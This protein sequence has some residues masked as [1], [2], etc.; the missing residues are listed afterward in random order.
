MK[1][2]HKHIGRV[3]I[4][5]LLAVNILVIVMLLLSAFCGHINPHTFGSEVSLGLL[6]PFL[7][8]ATF[9]FMI[10]WLIAGSKK[11]LWS[12]G[13]LLLCV[14]K[15]HTYCPVSMP[16]PVP[17]G[18]IKVVSY[19]TYGLGYGMKDS[20]AQAQMM[21]YLRHSDA[22]LLC[23]QESNYNL[24]HKQAVEE[25]VAH[26]QYTDSVFSSKS[27]NALTIYSKYPILDR[28]IIHSSSPG[29]MCVVYRVKIE[30]DTVYVVNCH[31]ISNSI[32]PEDKATYQKLVTI[33]DR[34]ITSED[35]LRLGRKVNDAGL[36]R[37]DQADSLAR[38][39]E[40]LGDKPVIVCGDFNE[41]P[42]GYVHTR[43]CRLLN[44]AYTASGNGPGIT[45]HLNKMYFRLDNILC[46][47]HWRSFG[48]RV[49]N[50]QK[51]SDHYPIE[52]WLKR[53][54]E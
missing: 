46:S 52:A 34:D 43:L 7:A 20:A 19:N 22:D 15:L 35:F 36:R 42:L 1:K 4:K 48:A 37:A 18:S 26:W 40:Q 32:N 17:K 41:S 45:Y 6:F 38:Y 8:V 49:D 50:R 44:D 39:L 3:F 28:H 21:D 54:K 5:L 51:M 30:S 29:H 14:F 25:A 53:V 13:A 24:K 31:F 9:I 23:A 12:F 2:V 27:W 47:R 33:S 11:W 16:Q 10:A